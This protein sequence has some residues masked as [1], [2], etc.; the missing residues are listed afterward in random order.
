[1]HEATVAEAILGL[2]LKSIPPETLL[3]KKINLVVGALSGIE[4]E[5]LDLYFAELSKGGKAA[6][7]ELNFSIKPAK[8]VCTVCGKVNL[9]NGREKLQEKCLSCGGLN[10]LE[11]EKLFYI[12][13]VEV[14]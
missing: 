7:A 13:H 2:V 12:D 6:G 3:V 11:T 1:M 10:K 9:F 5:S 4:K 14:I 8:L